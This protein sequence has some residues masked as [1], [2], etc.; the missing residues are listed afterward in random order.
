MIL[1]RDLVE[2]GLYPLDPIVTDFTFATFFVTL[3]G[4]VQSRYVTTPDF[5]MFRV[6]Q[7]FPNRK[8]RSRTETSGDGHS[9]P[10]L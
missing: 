9:A 3:F 8:K 1:G 6:N 5:V 2:Q 7:A 4:G 10:S